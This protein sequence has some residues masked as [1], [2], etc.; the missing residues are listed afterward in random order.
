MPGPER[1]Y[2]LTRGGEII[3]EVGTTRMGADARSSV[4]NGNCQA[5]DVRN[6]FVADAGPFVSQADKNPTWTILAL[7]WRTAD[8]IAAE[9]KRKSL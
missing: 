4:L 8:H 6:L 5:H 2:G 9:M 1:N 3:H 7:S